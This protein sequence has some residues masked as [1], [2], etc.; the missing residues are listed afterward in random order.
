[1]LCPCEVP[2]E[3]VE[4]AGCFAGPLLGLE[5]PRVSGD[6]AFLLPTSLWPLEGGFKNTR[7]A[8]WCWLRCEQATYLPLAWALKLRIE[9]SKGAPC[10]REQVSRGRLQ[11]LKATPGYGAGL[12]LAGWASFCFY[13]RC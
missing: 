8:C 5:T 9:T 2:R 4:A 6:A 1:M 7:R 3:Q 13:G 12:E 11:Q 10:P